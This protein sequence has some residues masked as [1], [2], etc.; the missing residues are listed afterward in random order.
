MDY[1]SQEKRLIRVSGKGRISAVPDL[2]RLPITLT[3]VK[4][5]Y[6]EATELSTTTTD[7]LMAAFAEQ[8]FR[9]ADLKTTWFSVDSKYD[10]VHDE[11]GEYRNIFIGY[12]FNHQLVIEFEADN[13]L[14]SRA[15][16]ALASSGTNAEF[17]VIYTLKNPEAAKNELLSEAIKDCKAKAEQLARAAG[18]RL[19]EITLIDYSWDDLPFSVEPMKSMRAMEDTYSEKMSLAIN[20]EDITLEDTVRIVWTIE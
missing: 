2:I 18:V 17:R 9:K 19:G 15:L 3:G 10:G 11:R 13:T 7:L 8:G 16:L 1:Q 12:E 4:A 14:I 5:S 20:P 6:E